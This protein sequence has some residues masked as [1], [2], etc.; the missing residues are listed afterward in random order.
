MTV[1]LGSLHCEYLTRPLGI[2]N[3]RPSL[4]WRLQSDDQNVMQAAYQIQVSDR[5][6]IVWDTG[7]I[8]SDK[9]IHIPY[10]GPTLQSRQRV[11][12]KV[13]V[14]DDKERESD[15]SAPAVWEMG[16]LNTS[17]WQGRS[18]STRK[19]RSTPKPLSQRHICERSFR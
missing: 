4:S 17:D 6:G 13:K 15:W 3:P 8:E 19:T 14:W 11:S 16:L 1:T 12:W 2:D 7:K 10:E 5:D 18:G 9:S